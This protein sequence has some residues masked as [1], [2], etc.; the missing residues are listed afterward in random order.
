MWSVG[1][2][3]DLYRGILNNLRRYSAYR[4]RSILFTPD[5]WTMHGDFLPKITVW[6]REGV[7]LEWR[8]PTNRISVM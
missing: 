7:T 8:K 4:K 1:N 3:N 2:S 6:G 5:V